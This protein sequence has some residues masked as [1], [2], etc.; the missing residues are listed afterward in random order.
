MAKIAD[1][2]R[3]RVLWNHDWDRPIGKNMAMSEDD[4]GLLVDGELLLDIK[5]AQETR[6]LIQN[7]AIDGLSIGYRVDDFSYD[8]NVRVIKSY[9]F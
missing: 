5:K 9:L 8:N 4:R 6:T 1:A 2:S 7:N 3:V